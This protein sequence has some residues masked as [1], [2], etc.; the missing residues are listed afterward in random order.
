MK[1]SIKAPGTA[2]NAC[3]RSRSWGRVPLWLATAV[4]SVFLSNTAIAYHAVYGAPECPAADSGMHEAAHLA[5]M[6]AGLVARVGS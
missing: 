3:R 1:I 4:L 5:C 6:A 2:H